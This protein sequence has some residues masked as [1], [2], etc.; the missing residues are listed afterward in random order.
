MQ[1][2]S[3][4]YAGVIVSVLG[5]LLTKAGIPFAPEQLAQVVANGVI[6]VGWLMA[7]K[8]RYRIGGINLCGKR[9]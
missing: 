7:L 8:G 9:I 3:L 4:T 1:N 5:Y 6:V 2:Y